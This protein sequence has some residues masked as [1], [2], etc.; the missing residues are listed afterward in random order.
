MGENR[1]LRNSFVY[2]VIL[3]A[4]LTLFYQYFGDNTKDTSEKTV[5]EIVALA[6]DGKLDRITETAG[7]TEIKAVTTDNQTLTARKN[8]ADDNIAAAIDAEAKIRSD[9]AL[10]QDPE[11]RAA[12]L[13]PYENAAKIK[14]KIENKAA[15]AWGG[16]LGAAL[17]FLL[18]TLLL[19]GFFVFFMRQ[20]Q[21]SN[22]Q[23]MSFGKSKARMFTGDKPSVTFADVAGQEEAKQDLTEVVE[24]LKF[25]EKFAQ[26]GARIPRGV[27]MVG[28]P[29]TGKTLLSRAVAGEAGVPF[30]SI[31]GSEFVEMFVGVGASRVR[32]LFEQAKRNA[33]C[34][35]FIDEV[36]AVGRQRG[37]GLGGSHDEREQTLNQILVEMDGFDTNTNVIVI[38]ATNR[39][40]VLDP[41][42]V[43][44]GRFDR[45]V[46]LDAPDLRGR[47]EVLKV[48]TKGKPLAEDV[49]LEAIAKLT[50]G[51]SGAD[52][53]NII[54][55]AAILAARRSKKRIAM[56]EMQDATER[57]MLGGPERRSRMMT[58]KQKELTAF[59]E[60]GHA[61]VAKAMPNANPVH[62]VTIIPR[63]MAGGY[64]LM[65]PEE[66]QNYMSV[67]Q[68]ESQIAVAL[69]GRVAEEIVLGDFTT[70]ASGDIQQITRM[71]RAMVTRYGMSAEL[72]PIAFGEKE[73]LIF[74]GRE[75]SEQRN[76]SDETSRKIDSEVKRLVDE[77]HERARLILNRDREVL[78]RMAEALIEHES[79]DGP[80][81]KA[82][83]DDV[84]PYV[85]NNGVYRGETLPTER[86]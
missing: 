4:A 33:P 19:I 22:N 51:S 17:T 31:S 82:I 35:V 84:T 71:A 39:P 65:I 16:I 66:D 61:I 37:A 48:H 54:N 32:D 78:N 55:E 58:P 27:L 80:A 57:I 53:A 44:P 34:I 12:A 25:P 45:Q 13:L 81:L 68:F 72:G 77:G 41:A 86:I 49:N 70:G 2:L 67:A 11:N 15:P 42:L 46:V 85:P 29:G 75:I 83:L 26:L 52:L 47:I 30:F 28:P 18:P 3:V 64:T 59:H 21:G 73:E 23:A 20:A 40:D 43:R 7:D 9:R 1:L 56:Q 60:A 8:N 14:Q 5:G 62:K 76:Y 63:G 69:G 24:F 36:D 38:A 74:L 79:L 6:L 50:P 10:L